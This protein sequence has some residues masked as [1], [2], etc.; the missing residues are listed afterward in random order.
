MEV[1]N[2]VVNDFFLPL[3]KSSS[4]AISWKPDVRSV[5]TCSGLMLYAR[6]AN[7]KMNYL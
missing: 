1:V 5:F 2:R 4:L 6:V 3:C 7:I